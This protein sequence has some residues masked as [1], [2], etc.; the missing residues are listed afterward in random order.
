MVRNSTEYQREYM[1]RYRQ[2]KKVQEDRLYEKYK[3]LY[4][5]MVTGNEDLESMQEKVE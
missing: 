3:I 5:N 4:N 2:R 1:R